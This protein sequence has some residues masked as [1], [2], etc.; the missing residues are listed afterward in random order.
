M[1]ISELIKVLE[2]VTK[3]NGDAKVTTNPS[4]HP[5]TGCNELQLLTK[6]ML[7]IEPLEFFTDNEVQHV[8]RTETVLH[9]G[10]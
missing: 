1:K 9:I 3:S 2:Q 4:W 7:N 6:D 10:C 5:L 8:K